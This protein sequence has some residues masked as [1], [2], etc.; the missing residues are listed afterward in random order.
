MAA[1]VVLNGA[2]TSSSISPAT[3]NRILK[4]AARLRYRP[5]AAA[6][7][8]AN[9]SMNTIGVVTVILGGAL[10]Q[11]FLEVFN[12]VIQEASRRGQNTTVFGLHDWERDAARIGGFCDGRIDGLILIA[13]LL[14]RAEGKTLPLHTPFVSIHAN[15]PLKGVV[16]LESDDEAGAFQMVRHLVSL[17]HRRIMHLAGRKGLLGADRRVRGYKRALAASGIPF[18]PELLVYSDF[19]LQDG[20]RAFSSW[21]KKN[22]GRPLPEAVFSANDANA[23]GVME[24]MAEIGLRAP[25]DLSI[26]GFD[27]TLAARTT[28]PQLTTVRQ[29]LGAMGSRAVEVLLNR[30]A[31][32]HGHQP[33]EETS[34]IVFP[35]EVVVRASVGAPPQAQRM[36]PALQ[37]RQF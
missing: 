7:A 28:V 32:L 16:N 2:R 29:P 37:A 33:G 26:A 18:N 17:G 31:A 20:Y 12:G 14:T 1:S 21:L 36:A 3:R 23:F 22:A 15:N 6:R 34:P 25:D 24:A 35:V 19:N 10:N 13:P 8:L 11:Y 5:N 4:A 9:R 27:D 30:V